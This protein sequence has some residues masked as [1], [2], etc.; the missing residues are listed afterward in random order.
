MKQ[1]LIFDTNFPSEHDNVGAY[2]RS[3]DGTLITHHTVGSDEGLDVYLLN[4]S[5]E[6]TGT[7]FDI[8]D[9][10][11]ASDSV[12]SWTHDGSGNAIGS[13]GGSLDV[14]ITNEI[15]VDLDGIYNAGTNADP[16][17][18]GLISHTRAAS[19]TDVQQVE[20]TTA[21]AIGQILS[22]AKG[23]VNAIDTNSFLHAIDDSNGNVEVLTRDNTSGGLNVHLAGTDVSIDVNDAALANTAIKA[24]SNDLDTANTAEDV[25]AV[26]D[27]LANRKYLYLYNDGNRAVYIGESGVTLTDGFPLEA[28]AMMMMRAGASIDIEFIGETGA[29]G[30]QASLR[31]LQLS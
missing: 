19:L 3:D 10:T 28:G 2:I 13:T 9:L 26:A 23:N 25:V 15:D 16:D 24:K 27:V 8:R 4:A 20:R 22:A 17:N 30:S 29:S 31:T 7:D 14:N 11:A 18:V 21:G 1:R 6:V 12:E 5:I